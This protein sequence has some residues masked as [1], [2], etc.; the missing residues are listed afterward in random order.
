MEV[1]ILDGE[2]E[3][4]VRVKQKEIE[5][6][7]TVEGSEAINIALEA[8]EDPTTDETV[9]DTSLFRAKTE[10]KDIKIFKGIL[11]ALTIKGAKYENE[12]FR[13]PEGNE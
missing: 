8:V 3:N 9:G 1:Y 12:P 7:V 6:Q 5:L 11:Q 2:A 4:F 13:F 10:L